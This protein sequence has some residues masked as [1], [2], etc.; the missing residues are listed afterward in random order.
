M[1]HWL[2][3][4]ALTA[5]VAASLVAASGTAAALGLGQI[6]VRSKAGQPLLAEIPIITSDP[7]EL[8]EL[9]A[10]LASPETF[11]R[12]GLQAPQGIVADLQFSVGTNARGRP[13]IRVTSDSPIEQPLV[14]FLVEVEWGQGRLV[15]EYSALVDTPRTVAAPV[16]TPI[17]APT[18]APPNVVQRP[19]QEPTP[20]PAPG[21]A[22]APM[23]ADV[24]AAGASPGEY[25]PVRRGDTLSAIAGRLGLT[26]GHSLDQ[27]MIALLRANPDAFIGGDINQLRR[28]AVLRVPQSSELAAVDAAQAS[29]IVRNRLQQWRQAR[30]AATPAAASGPVEPAARATSA[31]TAAAPA[32]RSTPVATGGGARLEIVPPAPSRARRAG[33]QSGLQAGGEG[34]MLSQELQQTKESLAARDAELQELKSRIAELERLQADQQRLLELKDS[35]LAAVQK[36]VVTAQQAP[37]PAPAPAPEARD[38]TWWPWLL[39]GA[40]LLAAA[41]G[42]WWRRRA[43]RARPAFRAPPASSSAPT[44][45]AAFPLPEPTVTNAATLPV[46]HI[47]DPSETSAAESDT[48]DHVESRAEAPGDGEVSPASD[49]QQPEPGMRSAAPPLD[50]RADMVPPAQGAFVPLWL[51]PSSTPP[52]A[53]A[54]AVLPDTA[55]SEVPASS[56]DDR[57]VLE[58]PSTEDLQATRTAA[59]EGRLDAPPSADGVPDSPQATFEA[60]P[61]PDASMPSIDPAVA[62]E[63]SEIM[64]AVESAMIARNERIE[65]A[66]AYMEL[67]DH[68]SA[69]QLL[70]EVAVT[71]DHASRQMAMRMLREIE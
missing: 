53:G 46:E 34:Q 55:G 26:N 21:Q 66:R 43:S 59:G 35:E 44:L 9:Q 52:A 16:Q 25:G 17:Q 12:V 39:G 51:T 10:R 45:A 11:A 3:H 33:T 29:E 62:A 8:E 30:R 71:G 47:D 67:G 22:R 68:E 56:A 2:R 41:L 57:Q 61:D 20:V 58:E 14:T 1:K 32:S 18:I 31:T 69:R 63:R 42:W 4:P 19:V 6:E 37:E 36:R 23:P 54:E 70:D 28:G 60:P 24:G 48:F 7:G 65:L 64:E 40:A 49:R 5:A 27:A 15:R 13:V 38:P 50:D